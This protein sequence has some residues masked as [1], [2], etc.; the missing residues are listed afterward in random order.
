MR[1]LSFRTQSANEKIVKRDWYVVD[2]TNQTLGRLCSNI[3]FTL[4]GKHKPY[5]TPHFDCGDYVI[6]INSGKSILTG[7]KNEDKEYQTYSLY[8]GGRKVEM[9]RALRQRRPNVM[10]ERAVK[11]MLP[12]NR[13]GRAMAKK[14]FVY[15]EATHPHQAQMPKELPISR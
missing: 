6:V 13:L 14:L 11:G 8:P 15:E 4:R 12:K 1:H 10:I 9:A 7:N 2:A 5:Y 3:A